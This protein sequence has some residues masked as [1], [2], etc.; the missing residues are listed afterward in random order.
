L[1]AEL[2]RNR[3]VL[4]KI[5]MIHNIDDLLFQYRLGEN[6]WTEMPCTAGWYNARIRFDG[7]VMPCCRCYISLGDLNK[8]SFREIWNGRKYLE[9]REKAVKK[10]GLASLSDSCACHWCIYA[11][12][13]YQVYR[14]SRSI[15]KIV[16]KEFA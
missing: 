7:T 4:S 6:S 5:G 15:L 16:G 11:G 14:K 9:F 3:E 12:N 1:I 8:E 10:D 13:N 2:I